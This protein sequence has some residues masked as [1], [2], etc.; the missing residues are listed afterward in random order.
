M[1][2]N[3]PLIFSIILALSELTPEEWRT[4]FWKRMEGLSDY[5]AE[6]APLAY[7][8]IWAAALALN[9]SEHELIDQGN[10]LFMEKC[11]NPQISRFLGAVSDIIS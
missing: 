3:Y 6:T 1:F 5:G 10:F 8:S 9:L 4:M 7:D 11:I 2:E